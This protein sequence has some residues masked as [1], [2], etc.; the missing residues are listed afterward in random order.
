M[1]N[2]RHGTRKRTRCS[3]IQGAQDAGPHFWRRWL[4]INSLVSGLFALLWVL[5]RSGSKP[6]RFAYPCQQAALS[7]ATLAFGGPLVAGL[8]A[9]RRKV[10]AGLR[11]RTGIAVAALGF[12]AASGM[13]G[14]FSRA[15][16]RPVPAVTPPAGYRA[17]VFHVT[18]CA[19]DPAGDRHIAVDN[20]I[21]LMGRNGLKLYQAPDETLLTGPDGIIARDDVVA[22]K[23]NY[24]WSDRGGT[25][26]DVLRGLIRRL[27][28][29]PA[30]FSGEIVVCENAQ[31]ASTNSFDRAANNAQDTSL[32]PHDVVV[33]FQ[34]L[35]YRVSHYD[36]TTRRGTQVDEY[37][38]GDLND[39]YVVYDYDAVL[40]GRISYPKF[41]TEYGTYVSLKHGV[42]DPGSGVYDRQ[43]L[44]FINMPVL[45]S[46]G[47]VYGATS[48][49]KNYMGVVT[50]ALSTNS[51]S[52]IQW[53][54]LG[55][56][57]GEIRPAD[58]NVL[59]CI[60]INADPNS[61]PWSS[62]AEATRVDQLVASVDPVAADMFAVKNILIP[63]FLSNGHTPPW[64]YPSA[65]PDDP[66]SR[67]REYL[68]NSMAYIL[69]AG[70]S[71]TND[72]GSIDV[73][74]GNGRAG[75][76]NSDSAVDMSDYLDFKGCFTGSGGGPVGAECAAAD[77]DGDTDVDCDDWA[78][79]TFAWTAPGSPPNLVAC[80]DIAIPAVSE[81]GVVMTALLVL[82]AGTLM[83]ARRRLPPQRGGVA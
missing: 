5:L 67:F 49:V 32:S 33:G 60:W 78:H 4:V 64:P 51:H 62:Y 27:V 36:W 48:C 41:R 65:D 42:W 21:T 71:V 34:T 68:D 77:F 22:I 10:V 55:A 75:D 44:K 38:S 35:G 66:A 18:N 8:I 52:S 19:E 6:S 13:W 9:A 82:T 15:E 20:L 26:T 80:S 29:H 46:H 58:L 47:A 72:L 25:N 23:I 16:E 7:T 17:E 63:G 53:G 39:G 74:S 69:A 31:F 24:Q 40:D 3:S 73:F 56:L 45:K 14:Y 43:R 61:G 12:A 70:Y 76:F 57:L 30:G 28:D 11:T 50:G 1:M 54:I 79:F 37:A 59:D 83:L 2:Y 81:W